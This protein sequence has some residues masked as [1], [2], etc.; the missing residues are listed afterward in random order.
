MR[1]K[2]SEPTTIARLNCPALE[3][4]VGDGQGVDEAR[5]DRLDVERRALGDAEAALN[6][7]GGSGK[8]SIRRGGRAHHEIDID[9]VD[10]GAHEGLARGGNAEVGG[11]LAVLGD[12]ALLDAGALLDPRVA[13]I[14][15]AR[16]IVI[17]HDALWQ[18]GADAADHGSN[19]CH[20]S[21]HPCARPKLGRAIARTSCGLT[22]SLAPPRPGP[23]C[24]AA[25]P[26]PLPAAPS[27]L[28][29]A[30]S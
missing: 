21:P 25:P 23:A 30:M 17:G 9:R 29:R 27:T 10:A 22:R 15:A 5:A 20:V 6:A 8:G 4:V 19:E 24:R 28:L 14:D 3:E 1:E 12:V 26:G 7:H 13:G 11:Q 18:M 16:Q 2:V